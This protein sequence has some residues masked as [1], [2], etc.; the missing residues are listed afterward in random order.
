MLGMAVAA[1]SQAHVPYLA[2]A[3]GSNFS[4][5]LGDGI[6]EGPQRCLSGSQLFPCSTS[7]VAVTG[8]EGVTA[9]SGGEEHA[10]ALL[11][12]GSVRAWGDNELGQLGDGNPGAVQPES[13]LPVAVWGL[14]CATSVA[15]G[16]RHSLALESDGTVRAWGDNESGQL[17]D[18]VSPERHPTSDVPVVVRE[19]RVAMRNVAAIAAGEEHSLAL[20]SNGE[21][22]AWGNGESGQLGDGNLHN[23]KEAVSV[24]KLTGVVAIAAGEEHSLALLSNGTIEAWGANS[25]GQLGDGTFAGPQTCTY[26][27]CST[28]RV[29]VSGLG[30]V[31]AIAAGGDHSLALLSNGTVMAWGENASGQ[32]GNGTTANSDVPVAVNGLSGV[33]AIAAGQEHSLA[34]L[35]NGTVMAWGANNEG[36]L[37]A[38]ASTGPQL[39]GPPGEEEGCSTTPVVVGGL[40]PMDVK[41]IA[42][43]SW[44]SL[45]FGPPNPK[46]TSVSPTEGL[47]VGGTVVTIS[48]SEFTG[49]TAVKF[50]SNEATAF[51][52]ESPTAITAVAPKG[53]GTVDVTVT[54]PEGTSP[55]SSAD[56]FSYVNPL[57][58]RPAVSGLTPAEGPAQGGTIVAINGTN[59]A[60]A[61]AVRFGSANAV[62]FTVNPE[63]T[64]ITAVSPEGEGAVDV[65]VT[66][67]GGTSATSPGDRFSY[68]LP[69]PPTVTGVTPN[70][71][72][73][74]TP[75]VVVITG[76]NFFHPTAV[77]MTGGQFYEQPV[78]GFIPVSETE[79]IAEL[80]QHSPLLEGPLTV[81]LRVMTPGGTSATSPA[82]RFSYALTPGVSRLATSAVTGKPRMPGVTPRM[83]HLREQV[84][85]RRQR[86]IEA[87]REAQTA[88]TARRRYTWSQRHGR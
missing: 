21:V 52:V 61:S 76:T 23:K 64:S 32:L 28:L 4:G 18:T 31:V 33:V 34:R 7:A 70:E 29:P 67:P 37:G 46:V 9:I 65:T 16:G 11:G 88:L 55:T 6:D 8:L 77:T 40:S 73:S 68:R 3:W 69:P 24:R 62:H 54:T 30:G 75:A 48:G 83:R 41:G 66:T 71:G 85:L 79:I 22:S 60:A 43:G 17:G 27:P 51:H 49:A 26:G 56:L 45:A 42:A 12:D 86:R 53:V 80:P 19:S 36:Q 47:E 1:P 81:D 44:H 25:E 72:G 78:T 63:G 84:R 14:C 87:L 20:L 57:A 35:A 39:C 58:P 13:D 10:L 38:G 50:G 82:D 15:A 5:Q 59:L 2:S 74:R